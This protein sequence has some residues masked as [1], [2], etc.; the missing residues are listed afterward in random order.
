[1]YGPNLPCTPS[2]LGSRQPGNSR[3]RLD[4]KSAGRRQT[5]HQRWLEK[6]FLTGRPMTLGTPVWPS[7]SLW[8]AGSIAH[9]HAILRKPRH[10]VRVF[11]GQLWLPIGM[12]PHHDQTMDSG[13]PELKRSDVRQDST[14]IYLPFIFELAAFREFSLWST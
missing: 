3:S 5:H 4:R 10:V 14:I 12:R 9:E 6:L 11:S 7:T 1:M 2:M 13:S 8:L